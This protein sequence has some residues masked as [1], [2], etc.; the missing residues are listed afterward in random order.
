MMKFFQRFS[1]FAYKSF[2]RFA[3]FIRYNSVGI[4][5]G[6]RINAKFAAEAVK[7]LNRNDYSSFNFFFDKIK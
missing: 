4:K 2:L 3:L 6:R 7:A 5:A 1:F